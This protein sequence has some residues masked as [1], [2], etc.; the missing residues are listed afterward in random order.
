MLPHFSVNMADLAGT[1]A[2]LRMTPV[3]EGVGEQTAQT[4]VATRPVNPSW[5][6]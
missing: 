1:Y 2:I 6:R 3:Q 4:S 5:V